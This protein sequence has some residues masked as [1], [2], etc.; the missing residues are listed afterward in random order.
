MFLL[1]FLFATKMKYINTCEK[2][3]GNSHCNYAVTRE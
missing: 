3:V 1:T 2:G